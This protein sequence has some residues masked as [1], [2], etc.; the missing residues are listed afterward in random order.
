MQISAF[1]G[2]ACPPDGP[3][4]LEP[5]VSTQSTRLCRQ[6]SVGA[7]RPLAPKVRHSRTGRF[8]LKNLQ[9]RTRVKFGGSPPG[10]TSI[11]QWLRCAG[12]AQVG[13]KQKQTSILVPNHSCNLLMV[14]I[15]QLTTAGLVARLVRGAQGNWGAHMKFHSMGV[16]A[17]VISACAVAL[18]FVLVPAQK[19]RAATLVHEY[20]FNGDT[21]NSVG[22]INGTLEGGATA[23]GGVLSL[24]GTTGYVQ[25]SGFAVPT[26]AFSIAF[27]ASS[28]D[29]M[30]GL[31]K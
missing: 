6:R 27:D 3:K 23:S 9:L 8:A 22:S 10:R 19:A 4:K 18:G 14:A 31:Q 1:G 28:R 13:K 5:I 30:L 2:I 25:L 15:G 24:N 7:A 26:G 11:L 20:K 12:S 29:K 16:R 17:V 21:T